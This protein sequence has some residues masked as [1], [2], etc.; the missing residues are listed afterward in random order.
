MQ[1]GE[2]TNE[3]TK[4]EAF[5]ATGKTD[6]PP[7]E[8]SSRN[9]YVEAN[10]ENADADSVTSVDY[11]GEKPN[12]TIDLKAE[13][14]RKNSSE[15]WEDATASEEAG[16]KQTAEGDKYTLEKEASAERTG[17]SRSK[18]NGYLW[19]RCCRMFEAE[20]G[21]N[22]IIRRDARQV[23]TMRG[24][25]ERGTS[26]F[27][28]AVQ[29]RLGGISESTFARGDAGDTGKNGLREPYKTNE[30]PRIGRA[31]RR[32]SLLSLL[33]IESERATLKFKFDTDGNASYYRSSAES[34][35]YIEKE[36]GR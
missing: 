13:I 8:C 36:K 27:S 19:K 6:T 20:R 26:L 15:S 25:G 31:R 4:I 7:V 29:T 11:N 5:F 2:W 12:S 35:D 23:S 9:S 22:L 18:V 32:L 14:H 1:S 10:V 16:S 34:G 24:N 28:K 3:K 21:I 30:F 33:E 17:A